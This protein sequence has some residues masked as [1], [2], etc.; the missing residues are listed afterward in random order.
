VALDGSPVLIDLGQP[1]YTAATF[2]DRRYEIWTMTSSWHNLPEVRGHQQ[3]VGARFRAVDVV[4]ALSGTSTDTPRGP[5]SGSVLDLE[6][7]D[8]YPAAAGLRSWRRTAALDRDARTVRISDA[9]DL[10][11]RGSHEDD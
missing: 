6:L 2:T 9:W 1:T 10:E 5:C 7:R 4:P 11:P 8:A 3:G